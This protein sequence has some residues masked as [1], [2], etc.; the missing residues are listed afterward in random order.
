MQ[1]L[2]ASVREAEEEARKQA[3]D[4]AAMSATVHRLKQELDATREQASDMISRLREE[5]Q[6]R[7]EELA[8]AK[9]AAAQ[10][11]VRPRRDEL[12]VLVSRVSS[13][14]V[15]DVLRAGLC[16][17]HGR[18]FFRAGLGVVARYPS[19]WGGGG[20]GVGA[21]WCFTDGR[22]AVGEGMYCAHASLPCSA[23][24]GDTP[25]PVIRLPP[26]CIPHRQALQGQLQAARSELGAVKADL[27]AKRA[28]ADE[29]G[30][31]LRGALAELAEAK[32]LLAVREGG[33]QDRL[34][35]A[36]EELVVVRQQV[37]LSCLCARVPLCVR[38]LVPVRVGCGMW[39]RGCVGAWARGCLGAWVPGCQCAIEWVNGC[40]ICCNEQRE[41]IW[42][43]RGMCHA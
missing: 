22:G 6:G 25:C 43:S 35:A 28:E 15:Y 34:K 33:T 19:P 23:A 11:Q 7:A 24:P 5:A 3:A 9:D 31:G 8:A 12:P 40:V 17:V 36:Q 39:V 37:R 18:V 21:Q 26:G 41:V 42:R 29:A 14:C 20:W 38:A 4:A 10:V 27:D 13:V 2:Q 30:K 32:R 16:A 1:T